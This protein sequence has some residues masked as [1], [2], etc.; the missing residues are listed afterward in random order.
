MGRDVLASTHSNAYRSIS[1]DIYSTKDYRKIWS[2]FNGPIPKDN[3]GRTYEIHHIDGKRSNNHIDNLKCVSLQ[4]HYDIHLSQGD[5]AACLRIAVKLDLSKE[6]IS[7]LA[8]EAGK[9]SNKIR[10]ENITHNFLGGKIQKE[11]IEKGTHNFLGKNNPVHQR[12]QNGSFHLDSKQNSKTA[13]NRVL[14]GTHPFLGPSAPSQIEWKCS[15]CEKQGK[16]K[17]NL[18]M[19]LRKCESVE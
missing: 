1:M 15:K 18:T 17:G 13:R 8:S 12:I 11:R 4:E 19:H 9:Q 14:N 6:K 3:E 16:G 5:K 7:N 2:Y 10:L